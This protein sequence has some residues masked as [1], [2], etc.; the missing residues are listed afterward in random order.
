MGYKANRIGE[1]HI[2]FQIKQRFDTEGAY[3]QMKFRKLFTIYSILIICLVS[4]NSDD[5]SAP[6]FNLSM[7]AEL[8]LNEVL[9]IMQENS[10]NRHQIDWPDFRNNVFSKVDGA[11]TFQDTYPGIREALILLN[12]NHSILSRLM[13]PVFSLAILGVTISK[14]PNLHCRRILDMS[15]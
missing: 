8:F 7:E 6:D 9:D 14:W 11:Q 2:G 15:V 13:E 4:C 10:I 3:Y 12:D 1:K 5:L